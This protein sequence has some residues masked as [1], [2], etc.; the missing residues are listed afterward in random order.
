MDADILRT[1]HIDNLSIIRHC[2]HHLVAIDVTD[3]SSK[4]EIGYLRIALV[5]P[6]IAL[7]LKKSHRPAELEVMFYLVILALAM[8]LHHK[9]VQRVIVTLPHLHGPPG[10]T[11][12]HL[13]LQSHLFGLLA[14]G[15]LF[16][17]ILH[18]E[19]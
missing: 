14:V 9:L 19:Q 6:R 17:S 2:H 15:F 18:L 11:T 16:G 1:L 7:A 4:R 13:P 5:F 3:G 12:F 8:Y 10:I